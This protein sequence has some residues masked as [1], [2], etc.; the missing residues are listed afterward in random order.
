MFRNAD[1]SGVISNVPPIIKGVIP[2][3]AP[4]MDAD[5]NEIA[6]VKSLLYRMPLGTY[7]GWNPI[8]TGPLKGRE[9]SLASGYI[10]F[11]K[12]AAERIALG[13]PRL[14]VQER[15]GSLGNYIIQSIVIGKQLVARRLLLPQDFRPL[16]TQ[17]KTQMASGGLLPLL[18]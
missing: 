1:G 9:G 7:T 11:P 4:K 5:G 8:A 13:D 18:P 14:S 3:L 2:S 6:G 16:V 15:Y 10:P 12:T 17:M